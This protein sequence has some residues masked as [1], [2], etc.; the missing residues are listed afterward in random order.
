LDIRHSGRQRPNGGAV[1]MVVV[2][3]RDENDI[4]SRQSLEVERGRDKA[5]RA[6]E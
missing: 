6:G 4:D 2:I 1:K 3:V 5:A